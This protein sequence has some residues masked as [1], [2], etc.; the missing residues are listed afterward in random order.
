ME[1]Q[2]WKTRLRSTSFVEAAVLRGDNHKAAFAGNGFVAA[3]D[4]LQLVK[5]AVTMA[6]SRHYALRSTA[7][8]SS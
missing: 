7:H 8:Q 4:S 1:W 3:E 2:G 6:V 5:S